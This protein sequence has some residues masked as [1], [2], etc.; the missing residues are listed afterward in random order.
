MAYAFNHGEAIRSFEEAL[1]HDPTAGMAYWG[2]AYSLGPNLHAGMS[3]SQE[4]RAV[5]AIR[6]ATALAKR[7]SAR[8]R[9]Y[10]AALSYRYSEEPGNHRQVLD[11]RY[12]DAMRLLARTYSRDPDAATLYA[13]ALMMRSPGEYW[14]RDGQPKR[15]TVEIMSLLERVLKQRPSHPGACHL[16]IHVVEASEHPERGLACGERLPNVAPGAGH[17]VH[18]PA[19]V[20]MRIG[21][22]AEA[23]E[24]AV[25]GAHADA[26]YLREKDADQSY[27]MFSYVHNLQVLWDA[28]AMDGRSGQASKAAA[29][30]A[31]AISP[32][33]QSTGS[34][35]E[36]LWTVPMMGHVRF[37][38]WEK[39]LKEPA[40]PDGFRY[41]MGVR[42][43]ARGLAYMRM[44]QLE[45]ADEERRRLGIVIDEM[46]DERVVGINPA[47]TIL[48][49]AEHVLVGELAAVRD[50]EE[51]AV[52]A[53]EEAVAIEDTL[54]YEEP[55]TWP[56]P[57]RQTLGAVL[58]SFGRA[59]EAEQRYRE[60]LHRHPRN[61]WSL[62]GLAQALNA[63]RKAEAARTIEKELRAAWARSDV[64]LSGS[65]F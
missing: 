13:E 46:T 37:G 45:R 53:L 29:E 63:Q 41:T 12:A 19:H 27:R 20:Y 26:A 38:R 62:Y 54:R 56:L 18:M 55:A 11:D 49:I 40:P 61:G 3:A 65:R 52:Q 8:E 59:A 60:D 51:L 1:R 44:D 9:D 21:R 28:S 35:R 4:R 58:L 25:H 50:Q 24:R 36:A 43:F 42:H 47:K 17:L 34:G 10:V 22:Y 39:V 16:Y 14:A 31:R 7:L 15:F 57:V 48:E 6:K 23:V 64:K 2:I 32:A 5:Q 30:L 33:T